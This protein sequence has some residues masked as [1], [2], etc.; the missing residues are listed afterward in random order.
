M[1]G[2]GKNVNTKYLKLYV[3]VVDSFQQNVIDLYGIVLK[4]VA[5]TVS[6]G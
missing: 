2:K 3:I 5:P 1:G 4:A 6:F